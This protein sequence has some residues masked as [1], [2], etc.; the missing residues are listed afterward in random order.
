MEAS[1]LEARLSHQSAELQ[2]LK[3]IDWSSALSS[4]RQLSVRLK[5]ERAEWERRVRETE[6]T[7][8]ETR[9]RLERLETELVV[10]RERQLAYLD[11]SNQ[12]KKA[13]LARLEAELSTLQLSA[14]G[15]SPLLMRRTGPSVTP[16]Q[17]PA[18]AQGGASAPGLWV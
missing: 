8:E 10:E 13:E 5:S 7:L 12:A 15:G 3:K 4:E 9:R 16:V 11:A 18:S 2:E 17:R 14:G 1:E 6:A